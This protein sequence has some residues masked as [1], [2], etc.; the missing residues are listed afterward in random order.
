[1]YVLGARSAR[2]WYRTNHFLVLSC[3]VRDGPAQCKYGTL[4]GLEP[5]SSV[6]ETDILTN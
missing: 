4:G 6:L 5:L 3:P 1:M 2:A